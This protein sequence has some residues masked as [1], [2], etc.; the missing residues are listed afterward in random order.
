MKEKMYH[1]IAILTVLLLWLPAISSAQT[2]A[3][4]TLNTEYFS[5]PTSRTYATCATDG[6]LAGPNV[7]DNC[8]LAKFN[9]PCTDNAACK[10][11]QTVTIE[12]I[13]VAIDSAELKAM[14]KDTANADRKATMDM[15]ANIKTFNLKEKEVRDKWFD[16]FPSPTAPITNAAITALQ[17]KDASRA[18]IVCGRSGTIDDVSCG[19]RGTGCN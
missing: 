4:G 18:Q 7:D 11:D 14:F 13:N 9:Q 10:V 12:Q 3:Q 15:L 8:V 5:D 16:V 1:G 19:L 2:C 17:K 6:N